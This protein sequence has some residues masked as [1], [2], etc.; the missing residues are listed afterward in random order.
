MA[1]F[2]FVHGCHA[3]RMHWAQV[4]AILLLEVSLVNEV[5]YSE[6]QIQHLGLLNGQSVGAFLGFEE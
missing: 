3:P 1:T 5:K 4:A 6:A 2:E